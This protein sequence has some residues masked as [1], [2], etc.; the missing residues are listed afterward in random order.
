MTLLKID[1]DSYYIRHPSFYNIYPIFDELHASARVDLRGNKSRE[2]TVDD[3]YGRMFTFE[4]PAEIALYGKTRA[5]DY[6]VKNNTLEVVDEFRVPYRRIPV[7]KADSLEDIKQIIAIQRST[8]DHHVYLLRGQTT[9]HLVP[10]SK[11]ETLLLYGSESEPEPSLMPSF[12]RSSFDK[13]FIQSMWLGI[14]DMS[15]VIFLLIFKMN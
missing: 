1:P 11:E 12:L 5:L 10:R 4:Y 9:N 8:D 7:F 6:Y 14:A 13:L 15:F 3:Y 2:Y